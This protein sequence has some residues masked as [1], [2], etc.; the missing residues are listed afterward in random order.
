MQ[1]A[2]EL[3]QLLDRID[4]RGYPAYKDTKGQYQ[5][6]GYVFSI[7]HVQGDPFASPSK[8][9]V[10]VK[11]STAG[12]PEE[13][14]KGRHQRAALQD[15]MTRQFYRAI[16][17]YAFRAKGSGKSG[18]ISVSKCGQEVLER[19]ACEINP[20]NG[21]VKLR[22]EVGFPAN[23]RTINARELEKIVFGFL[24]ECVEQSLFYKNCDKKRVRSII[25]LAEDQQY[26]RDELE[27]NDLIAFVAN[28]AILPRES[29][30]SDKPMK[31]AVR[32]QSPKEME[33]T[34]KLPHKGEI[35]GMG[36]RRGITLIVGGGYHGKSTLLKALEL[37]VYNHIQGDGREYVITKDDAMKIR[38]EDGRSI[39]KTDISMFIND[40]PN[41]KDTRG[42]YTE[43]ASGST[44]Q[45]ANVIESMEAGASVMLI[46]EDTSATNFMIRDEL[47]QRVIHR[48]M[49]PITPFI[50]RI[51]ELYQV[52]GIST[53][54]VAGS[55]GAYFHIAD[56][57][58]QMDRYEPKE[59]TK[60]AK[61]TAKDFPAMSGM[62]NP[63]EKPVFIR[64]PRQGRGFKP[65]DRIKMK[66]MGKEMV[67][68]NRENIDLRYVEQLADTEQ[69]SALGY[70]VRYAEKHLF[71]GKDSIQNVV[72]KLE[73]KICREGLSSLCESNAS[74][75]NLAMPRRQEIFACLNRYR[76]LN[77]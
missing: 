13:L 39:K 17:K 70:C 3:K 1:S 42:F 11:G 25:D 75:A 5:F 59:I 65:N 10:Q 63:A 58:I 77:L 37:G 27:K 72:D 47:M 45:A 67:Q 49:E 30:V 62:E 74:V 6:Q 28:G 46:D 32:F 31:G 38:A 36:I 24:P 55:S 60:L 20:K 43:D 61:E 2:V 15:E 35:S 66:T 71:Q 40:L 56:T 12:F 8:V 4:H 16:Q 44:S 48:D 7:D 57:I 14:Y 21:D 22:F 53:V 18:L 76:G 23:G 51:L 50:D 33:V 29:G 54:I 9:S 41:G 34:M 73:E 68:L 19:T 52:Y 26:I 69:V 64:C